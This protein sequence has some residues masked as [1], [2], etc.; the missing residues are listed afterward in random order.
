[1]TDILNFAHGPGNVRRVMA[2]SITYNIIIGLNVPEN[3][4]MYK[5][6]IPKGDWSARILYSASKKAEV[7]AANYLFANLHH[8]DLVVLMVAC[9]HKINFVL[10]EPITFTKIIV[11]YNPQET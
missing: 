4:G 2:R 8:E 9:V 10:S 11:Y 1:M 3:K 5:P 6:Y 7:G